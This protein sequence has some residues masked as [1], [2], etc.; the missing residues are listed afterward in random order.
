MVFFAQ[1]YFH[2]A[3]ITVKNY[4]VLSKRYNS[5][6][7]LKM[8]YSGWITEMECGNDIGERRGGGRNAA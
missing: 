7:V 8:Y 3:C 2:K 1:T 6:T 5:S 4:K